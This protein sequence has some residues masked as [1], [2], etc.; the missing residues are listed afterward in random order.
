MI[1]K[2]HTMRA[3]EKKI[4]SLKIPKKTKSFYRPKIRKSSPTL[5]RRG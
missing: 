3:R 5:S 2:Q 4:L 1:K